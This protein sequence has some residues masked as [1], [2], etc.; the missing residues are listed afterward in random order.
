M[1]FAKFLLPLHITKSVRG[2]FI[3]N[4]KTLI[5]CKQFPPIETLPQLCSFLRARNASPETTAQARKLWR[6]YQ[7]STTPES[8]Q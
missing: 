5:G 2:D 8:V 6:T 1:S 7:K 4:A 3:E